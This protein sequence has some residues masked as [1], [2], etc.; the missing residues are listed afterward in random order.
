MNN[1][2]PTSY[3]P[4]LSVCT[5]LVILNIQSMINETLA[6]LFFITKDDQ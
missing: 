3:G 5:I 1:E 2:I 6:Y 4:L